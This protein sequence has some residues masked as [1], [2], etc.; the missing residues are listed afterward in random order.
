V[1]TVHVTTLLI[2]AGEDGDGNNWVS[3]GMGMTAAV[4]VGYGQ[5]AWGQMQT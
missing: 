1:E 2:S 3:M 4:W 5:Q